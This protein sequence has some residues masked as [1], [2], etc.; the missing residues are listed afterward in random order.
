[1]RTPLFAS[2]LLLA[3]GAAGLTAQSDPWAAAIDRAAALHRAGDLIA[4]EA[5]LQQALSLARAQ[6]G[7]GLAVAVTL[8]HL[9]ALHGSLD[10]VPQAERTCRE[11]LAAITTLTDGPDMASLRVRVIV[12]L[13]TLYIDGGQ[14][15]KAERL[16]VE[17]LAAR[18]TTQ[19]EAARLWVIIAALHMGRERQPEAEAWFLRALPVL[20]TAGDLPAAASVLNN[21]AVIALARNQHQAAAA[22]LE[23]AVAHWEGSGSPQELALAR[24]LA[25]L[26]RVRRAAGR[27]HEAVPLLER[28]LA[29]TERHLGEEHAWTAAVL[30][31]LA[32]TLPKAGRRTEAKQARQRAARAEAAAALRDDTR[33]TVDVLDLTL[34]ARPGGKR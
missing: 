1:M 20:E 15:G 7:D 5:A 18:T 26:A 29:I 31:L 34:R 11:A 14:Y 25:N 8:A 22:R 28:A 24:G 16:G 9:G 19:P 17:H 33:H 3:A 6:G 10:R 4:A 13:A 12:N 2:L 27:A 21:L 23:R 30:R 32:E